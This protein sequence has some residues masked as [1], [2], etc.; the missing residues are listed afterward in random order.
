MSRFVRPSKY[1][2]VYGTAARKEDFYDNIKVRAPSM[3]WRPHCA[4]VALPLSLSCVAVA[5]RCRTM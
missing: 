5:R 4:D 3:R 1:R 2:H